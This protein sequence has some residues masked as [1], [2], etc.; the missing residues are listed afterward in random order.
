MAVA[1]RNLPQQESGVPSG[2]ASPRRL[3][4]A[5]ERACRRI[6]PL[7]PLRHFVAVNP[8]L[9]LT[10][11]AFAE[12]ARRMERIA[13]TR[14][15]M[16]RAFYRD[17]IATGRIDDEALA[18]ALRRA[19]H[20][21]HL[22]RNMA[23]LEQVLSAAPAIRPQPLETIADVAGD[24]TGHDWSSLVS[25]RIASW[26]AS[27]FDQGQASWFA[28]GRES[29][30][31]AA[32]RE[33]AMLDLTPQVMGLRDFRRIVRSLPGTARM[34]ISEGLMRLGVGD[35]V[36]EIYL[37][38]LL[39][40]LQGWAGYARYLAWQSELHGHADTTVRE[41]L[42]VRLA[43]EVAILEAHRDNPA[44]TARW[45]HARERM[46]QPWTDDAA[47][48]LD[49]VLQAAF[50]I[51]WQRRL[52]GR[53]HT[54]RTP[55]TAS[56]KAVQMAFCIDVRSEVFRRALERTTPDV[57][58]LGLAG[59]F[60]MPLEYVPLGHADGNAQCPVLLAP[61]ITV[62][63]RVRGA[64]PDEQAVITQ[65]LR[66][67]RRVAA[68]WSWFRLAA[69]S[70]FAFV[71]SLGW[72]YGMKLVTDSLRAFPGSHPVRPEPD[73]AN[74]H[75]APDI[76][77]GVLQGRVAGIDPE[78]RVRLALGALQA[79]SLRRDFARLVVLAGHGAASVNNPHARG[80]DCGACGGHS[81]VVNAR[82]AASVLNDPA[83]RRALAGQGIVI[84]DDT[85]FMGALHNTTTDAVTLFDEDDLPAS[86]A[87]D[88][89]RLQQWLADAGRHARAERADAL[90][91]DGR[92]A[93]ID[94][95]I[96]GRSRDWSQVRP[97]WG[98]AGCA[99]CIIAP[100][101]RTRGLDLAGRAFLN[102]YDWTQ[103][104]NFAV[105]ESIMTAPMIVGAWINLQYYASTVD[106]PT[107]GS[108]NKVLHNIVGRLGVVEGNGGDLRT[109]LPLQ[110]VHDGSKFVHEPMRM[111][112]IISAPIEGINA[113]IAKH[114]AVRELVENGWLHLFAWPE[115]PAPLQRY[116]GSLQ[117]ETAT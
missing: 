62:R 7:W 27:H 43:W 44:V 108:G 34:M 96:I 61:T 15:T 70:S 85:R 8:F 94:A 41:L 19:P 67:R 1:V 13:G 55:A 107:F 105:L 23:T 16:P 58:T 47:L 69:V 20:P 104:E 38:R 32:W 57:E 17:A 78:T 64:S 28:P 26:A 30:A 111:S 9:G 35:D 53:L 91:V 63:E 117:W 10:D 83:V 74:D 115:A 45:Q 33:E 68:A 12:A 89:A 86:H 11:L 113:V 76:T 114:R 65:K 71:E 39:M 49:Q 87:E 99:A 48:E 21:E 112:V 97:E 24:V 29:N 60:G 79:M 46:R 92:G 101:S 56:R 4:A 109:G 50:E 81:G 51:S 80:L 40:T 110:S 77:P 54:H 82:V 84:P 3:L 102:S 100:R 14:L 59:F 52:I 22:P 90:N 93:S 42:A 5:A 18:L 116:C 37:H 103:D 106:N 31:Y 72:I 98:L 75:L 88:L 25:E 73:A 66:L 95:A 6:A 2:N 36:A